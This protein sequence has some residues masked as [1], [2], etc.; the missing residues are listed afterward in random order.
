MST[1]Q[2]FIWNHFQNDEEGLETFDVAKTRISWCAKNTK[3]FECVL[4][5]GIGNSYLEQLLVRKKVDLYCLDPNKESINRVKKKLNLNEKAMVGSCHNIPFESNKFDVVILSEVIEHLSHDILVKTFE[6]INRVL[7]KNGRFVGTT[8]SDEKLSLSSVICPKCNNQFHRWGHIHTFTKKKLYQKL[9]KTFD[10]INI[11]LKYFGSTHIVGRI[12]TLIRELFFKIGLLHPYNTNLVFICKKR[13]INQ[14][15]TK[16]KVLYLIGTM[17]VGGAEKQLINIMNYVVN[18]YD[19]NLMLLSE[20]G[21]LLKNLDK[22]IKVFFPLITKRFFLSKY[23]ST[24][25]NVFRCFYLIRKKNI[26]VVHTFLPYSYFIAFLSMVFIKK[27][28]FIMSRRS[29]SYYHKNKLL[30]IEKYFHKYLDFATCNSTHIS[31][32]LTNEGVRSDKI[33]VIYN[34]VI[35]NKRKEEL[36]KKILD[37]S[38]RKKII[39]HTANLIP[40]KNQEMLIYAIKQ[41][42][43]EDTV[44]LFLGNFQNKEYYKYLRSLVASFSLSNKV[45]FLG[46][47]SEVYPYLKIADIGVLTSKTEGLPNAVLEYMMCKLPVIATPVGGIPEIIDDKKNGFFVE[48]PQE[49]SKKISLLLSNKNMRIRFGENGLKKIKEN[50]SSSNLKEYIKLYDELC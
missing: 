25:L 14:I 41:V 38:K 16:K 10:N 48:T 11:K 3:S 27:T 21:V 23:I 45:L 37:L 34:S 29:E 33:K 15:E 43:M 5:V 26:N 18:K 40:Y 31:N 32:Q 50:F 2:D 42:N 12:A 13:I 49:L 1:N 39:V 19:V 7:K 36:P 22:K 6:E 28:T 4:T 47:V 46:A 35:N 30:K 8:P 24:F 9:N 17:H 44:V 20:K